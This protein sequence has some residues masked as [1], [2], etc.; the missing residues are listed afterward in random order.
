MPDFELLCRRRSS[1]HQKNPCRLK[2]ISHQPGSKYERLSL[3]F[4]ILDCSNM[5]PKTKQ[6][7][8]H[9]VLC[10][11]TDRNMS[12]N[13]LTF[14]YHFWGSKIMYRVRYINF[15]HIFLNTIILNLLGQSHDFTSSNSPLHITPCPVPFRK[16][17]LFATMVFVLQL[18]P[19]SFHG[20]IIQS[21]RQTR[22]IWQ[23][24]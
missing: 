14:F 2:N 13:R 8:S 22:N 12:L 19:V 11:L 6:F 1:H 4:H 24:C 3:S 21:S 5:F 20:P 18:H 23:E 9:T 10:T 7:H 15:K 17:A 16:I